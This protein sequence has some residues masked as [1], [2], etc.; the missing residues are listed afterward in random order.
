MADAKTVIPEQV[1]ELLGVYRDKLAMVAFPEISLEILEKL[2]AE[3][4][5]QEQVLV[6]A[7][8]QV[9]EAQE[10]LETVME[11]LLQRCQRGLAYAKV[12]AEGDETLS[13]L[14]SSI[15]F[16]KSARIPKRTSSGEKSRTPVEPRPVKPKRAPVEAQIEVATV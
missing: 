9:D 12:Y 1:N 13:K 3:V 15:N 10:A 11:T 7:R 16:G 2:V 6:E 5:E 14:L 4:G 8:K